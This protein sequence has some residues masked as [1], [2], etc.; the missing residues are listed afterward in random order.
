MAQLDVRSNEE[1]RPSKKRQLHEISGGIE[2]SQDYPAKKRKLDDREEQKASVQ[3]PV[4][5]SH[6]NS[7]ESASARNRLSLLQQVISGR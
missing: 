4:E 2:S 1:E 3:R 7:P 5:G 6:C